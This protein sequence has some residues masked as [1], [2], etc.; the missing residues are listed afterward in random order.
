[1]VYRMG[2]KTITVDADVFEEL[3]DMKGEDL[4][5]ND[6]LVRLADDS[7][8]VTV[9]EATPDELAEMTAK[10]VTDELEARFR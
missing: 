4:S 6:F 2:R 5:W 10:R 3:A 1:M 9:M 8:G 7:T